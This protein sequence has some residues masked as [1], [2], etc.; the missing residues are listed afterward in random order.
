M[1]SKSELIAC[2]ALNF[3]R[4]GSKRFTLDELANQLGISK[5]TIY[6]YFNNQED[7]K[8]TNLTELMKIIIH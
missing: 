5:K 7:D 6:H 2:S 4:F 8:D 1:I 3:T